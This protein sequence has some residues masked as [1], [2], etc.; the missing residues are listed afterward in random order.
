MTLIHDYLCVIC[1]V[2]RIRTQDL[3]PHTYLPYHL[4]YTTNVIYMPLNNHQD[5]YLIRFLCQS[6]FKACLTIYKFETFFNHVKMYLYMTID[7]VRYAF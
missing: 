1:V 7:V 6:Q 5:T 4:T 3:S 2:C